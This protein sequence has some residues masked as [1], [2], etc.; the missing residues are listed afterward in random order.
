MDRMSNL[1]F[2]QK[3]IA[4]I[5]AIGT[6]LIIIFNR[7]FSMIAPDAGREEPGASQNQSQNLSVVGTSPDPLDGATILPMQVVEV[8]FSE[9]MVNDPARIILEPEVKYN[10]QLSADHKTMQIQPLE[11]YKL[12][13]S[14]TLTIKSGYASDNG[15]K[16]ESDKVFNFQTINY[17][18]V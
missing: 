15:K 16:L 3:L 12:G 1:T 5:I 14:Y 13:Q 10:A 9:G 4:A 7:G 18:G 17:N 11:P 6:I 2:K 8:Q